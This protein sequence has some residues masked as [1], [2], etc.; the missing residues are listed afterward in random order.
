MADHYLDCIFDLPGIPGFAL[1]GIDAL[2]QNS[3]ADSLVA[4][5]SLKPRCNVVFLRVYRKDLTPSSF[6]QFLLDLLDQSPFLGI[7]T[8]LGKVSRLRNDESYLALEFR[9]DLNAVERPDSIRMIG[10]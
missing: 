8:V 3:G 9:I 1:G 6:C 7:D 2:P 4:Q 10:I 5:D